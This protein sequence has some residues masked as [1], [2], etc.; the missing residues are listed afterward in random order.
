MKMS[1]ARFVTFR[2]NKA[3]AFIR[4]MGIPHPVMGNVQ[5]IHGSSFSR[6]IKV[7]IT[8]LTRM[9]RLNPANMRISPRSGGLVIDGG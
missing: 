2:I 4:S 1:V 3:F 7:P 8:I 6:P 9:H 5:L